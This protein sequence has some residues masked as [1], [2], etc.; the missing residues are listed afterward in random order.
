MAELPKVRVDDPPPTALP[1]GFDGPVFPCLPPDQPLPLC[2]AGKPM[3]SALTGY[4]GTRSAWVLP[5]HFFLYSRSCFEPLRARQSLVSG[6][7]RFCGPATTSGC[8][9][10]CRAVRETQQQTRQ[11]LLQAPSPMG[12]V[13]DFFFFNKP[14]TQ[15]KPTF[16]EAFCV[17]FSEM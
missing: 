14:K 3:Y 6:W 4:K 5:G 7:H 13:T 1:A 10:R 9:R 17:L 15:S 8:F 2:L 11:Q 12:E 16:S